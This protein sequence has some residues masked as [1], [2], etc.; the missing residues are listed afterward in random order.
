MKHTFILPDLKK[1]LSDKRFWKPGQMDS[2]NGK[3]ERFMSQSTVPFDDFI[4]EKLEIKRGDVVLSLASNHGDWAKAIKEKG[5]IVDYTEFSKYFIDY[6]KKRI[7]FRKY[8]TKDFALIPEKPNRYDWSFSYEPVSGKRALPIAI[9]RSLLNKKGGII[10]YYDEDQPGKSKDWPK[11]IKTI[12]QTYRAEFK[13]KSEYFEAFRH[14]ADNF[15]TYKKADKKFKVFIIRTNNTAKNK[16]LK[17][18]KMLKMLKINN[19]VCN[20][21]DSLKRLDNLKDLFLDEFTKKV[22]FVSKEKK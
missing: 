19:K 21:L 13:V 4:L 11:L 22:E 12:A 3:K 6:I 17:D 5:C 9:M 14:Q 18:L 20:H 16:V 15:G 2:K 1:I 10:M 7:K 8:L